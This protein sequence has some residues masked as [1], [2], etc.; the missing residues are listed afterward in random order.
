MCTRHTKSC[1]AV[2]PCACRRVSW[3]RFLPPEPAPG[4]PG[5]PRRQRV[6][7]AVRK[8][9]WGR[10]GPGR[11]S[12]TEWLPQAAGPSLGGP[13]ALRSGPGVRR[14]RLAV[15]GAAQQGGNPS[16]APGASPRVPGRPR[17]FVLW[18]EHGVCGPNFP[19]D[20]LCGHRS[21]APPPQPTAGPTCWVGGREGLWP[22]PALRPQLLLSSQSCE[23]G[24]SDFYDRSMVLGSPEGPRTCNY[25]PGV[26]WSDS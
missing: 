1:T 8:P 4:W 19:V 3:R 24:Q 26:C 17:N 14:R 20:L 5:S 16:L 18:G 10:G 11:G 6:Q 23:G 9:V 7:G 15:R 25:F 2:R 13:G 21:L 12:G 22:A